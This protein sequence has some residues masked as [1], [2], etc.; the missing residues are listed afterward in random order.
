ME[1]TPH[2]KIIQSSTE[3]IETSKIK[4]AV[5]TL[6]IELKDEAERIEQNRSIPKEIIKR[7]KSTGI[8]RLVKPRLFGG[9]EENPTVMI[10][11]LSQLAMGCAST[12]WVSA[13]CGLHPWMLGTF[14]LAAQEDVWLDDVDT[15]ITGTYAPSNQAQ[16]V[17]DGI[18][19]SGSWQFA[20]GCQNA[21]WAILGLLLPNEKKVKKNPAAFV[22]VPMAEVVIEDMWYAMGLAGTGSNNLHLNNV[23]VP[24]HRIM[25]FEDMSSGQ[26]PGAAAHN[27]FV[28]NIPFLSV[29]PYSIISVALGAAKGAL[30]AFV[31]DT[32]NRKTRGGTT[33]AGH[34]VGGF[35][36]VQ[37]RV[38]EAAASIETGF[39]ILRRDLE[40][41][42]AAA[43]SGAGL[44]I[45]RRIENRRNQ[46]MAMRLAVQSVN[47]LFSC[48]G[49][50]GLLL[51]QPIQRAWRDVNAAARHAGLNWDVQSTLSG[52]HALGYDTTGGY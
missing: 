28:Y 4:D 52:R 7:V 25:S 44:S 5:H 3:A 43:K 39:G 50:S 2:P 51:N 47:A 13:V 11:V 37:S 1:T 14:P 31:D 19:I 22:I 20:S 35:P 49:G 29:V 10:D 9:L 8:F 30:D 16:K 18:C 6:Y 26:T 36:I 34:K 27:S 42:Y 41:N 48:V 45:T 15:F 40:Y 12:A 33:D 46:A 21:D 23:F 24:D 38:A 17:R 32:A